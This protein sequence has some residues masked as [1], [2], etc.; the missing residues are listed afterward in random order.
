MLYVDDMLIACQDASKI[1]ELKRMLSSVFDMKN[2]GTAKKILGMEIKR[3]REKGRLFLSQGKYIEKVLER[4][5]MINAKPVSTPLALHFNLSAKQSPSTEAELEAMKKVPYASVVGCLMYA[6]VC[7]RPDLAQAISVVS[8][9]MSNPGN[10]HWKA[11]KWILRYLKGTKS[12][13]IML[14]RQQRDACITGFV[15]SDYGGDLDKR[16]STTGYGMFS[17]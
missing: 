10:D 6:M 8:K 14:E 12:T 5:N 3:E 1:D 4:F 9:Y 15:D 16:R 2:L 17:L 13:G 7:T 11:V